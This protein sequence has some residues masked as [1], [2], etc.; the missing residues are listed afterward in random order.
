MS[1]SNPTL[2][3]CN[4]REFFFLLSDVLLCPR[5]TLTIKEDFEL[6]F[7]LLVFFVVVDFFT[8]SSDFLMKVWSTFN[9]S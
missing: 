5:S 3:L 6:E 1:P 8:N 2:L 7:M 4:H 9:K